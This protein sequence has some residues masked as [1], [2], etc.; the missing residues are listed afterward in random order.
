MKTTSSGRLMP[1]TRRRLE[2][3]W[4]CTTRFYVRNLLLQLKCIALHSGK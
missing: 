1:R 4:F 2:I 3:E